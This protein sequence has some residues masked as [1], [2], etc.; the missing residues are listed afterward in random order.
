M[1][2]GQLL[3]SYFLEYQQRMINTVV[4]WW[5]NIVAVI[6]H[7]T[8]NEDNLERKLKTENS[9]S[10]YPQEKMICHK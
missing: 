4:N 6:T 9:E 5:N 3:G 1:V 8:R 10:H 2:P 7:D